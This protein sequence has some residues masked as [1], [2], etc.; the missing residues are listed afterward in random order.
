MSASTLV[1]L[2]P[3]IWM[4]IISPAFGLVAVCISLRGMLSMAKLLHEGVPLSAHYWLGLPAGLAILWLGLSC[5]LFPQFE[6]VVFSEDGVMQESR[7]PLLGMF[8][9]SIAWDEVTL[10]IVQHTRS[11]VPYPAE[12][13]KGNARIS[14]AFVSSSE[15]ALPTVLKHVPDERIRG[16]RGQTGL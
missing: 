1:N 10:V 15:S 2:R 12:I 5:A 7:I 9:S 8:A 13:R 14:T 4:R 16:L 11:G 3:S 6:R